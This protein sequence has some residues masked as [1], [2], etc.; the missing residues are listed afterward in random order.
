M[1]E[2]MLV[3]ISKPLSAIEIE[4]IDSFLF[5]Y[6][7]RP[8][9]V[10]HLRKYA[11]ERLPP[12]DVV[13]HLEK[14]CCIGILEKVPTETIPAASSPLSYL[15]ATSPTG[16]RRLARLYLMGLRIT[17]EDRWAMSGSYF[18]GSPY[19]EMHLTPSLVESILREKGVGTNKAVKPM[20]ALVQ[21]SPTALVRLLGDWTPCRQESAATDAFEMIEHLFFL[22]V[23]DAIRDLAATRLVP[24]RSTVSIATVRP[25]N[26]LAQRHDPALLELVLKDGSIIGIEARFDTN[27]DFYQGEDDSPEDFAEIT[28]NPENCRVDFWWDHSPPLSG[29]T[30]LETKIGYSFEKPE[31]LRQM[32]SESEIP[33][34]KSKRPHLLK[35]AAFLGDAILESYLTTELLGRCRLATAEELHEL[36]K[37]VGKNESLAP[38]ARELGL[39]VSVNFPY[40]SGSPRLKIE[41]DGMLGDSLE[42]LVGIAYLDGGLKA[43]QTV[44]RRL[45]AQSLEAAAPMNWCILKREGE[46][47][48]PPESGDH[49]NVHPEKDKE[50]DQDKS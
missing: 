17:R 26:T 48:S 41:E 50:Q 10:A 23:F 32:L 3:E 21:I 44:V 49:A 25:Q 18:L 34:T 36:R 45:M 9:D 37:K 40:A 4:I 5:S 1:S 38:L 20:L 33:G 15:L 19:S 43:S 35:Q 7:N 2:A 8:V 6:P 24:D 11:L 16:F 12:E 39:K 13:S 28:R 30:G 46:A 31:L 29:D 27:H 14:M 47:E 42:A 22:M